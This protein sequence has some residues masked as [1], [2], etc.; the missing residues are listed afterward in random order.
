MKLTNKLD[1]SEW[2]FDQCEIGNDTEDMRDLIKT[3]RYA[4]LYCRFIK[5][6]PEIRKYITDNIMMLNALKR[7]RK[8]DKTNENR[9]YS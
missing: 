3:E 1:M 9:R 4:F 2:A 7:K 8:F 5:D 6:R